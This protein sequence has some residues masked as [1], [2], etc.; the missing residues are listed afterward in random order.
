MDWLQFCLAMSMAF[1][2]LES[3]A[4]GLRADMRERSWLGFWAMVWLIC[5]ALVAAY[6]LLKHFQETT[7]FYLIP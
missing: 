6:R 4:S 3:M 5:C 7:N 1:V 2:G